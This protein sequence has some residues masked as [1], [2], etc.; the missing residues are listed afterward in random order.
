MKKKDIVREAALRSTIHSIPK[1]VSTKIKFVKLIW[2]IASLFSISFCGFLIIITVNEYFHYNVVTNIQVFSEKISEFPTITYCNGNPLVTDKA[3]QYIDKLILENSSNQNSLTTFPFNESEKLKSNSVDLFY[4]FLLSKISNEMTKE[5]KMSLGY[6][7]EV[8]FVDCEFDSDYCKAANLYFHPLYGNCVKFNNGLDIDNNEIPIL[9]TRAV[10]SLNGLS[11][12]YFVGNNNNPIQIKPAAKGGILLIGNNSYLEDLQQQGIYIGTNK[13]TNIEV[14]RTFIKKL[15]PKHGDCM[16]D[17]TKSKS[18]LYKYI[19]KSKK[20][21][22]QKD[23]FELIK[24]E[25]IMDKCNCSFFIFRKLNEN[26]KNCDTFN[27]IACSV[28]YRTYWYR[29]NQNKLSLCPLECDSVEYSFTISSLSP[30]TSGFINWIRNTTNTTSHLSQNGT[31]DDQLIANSLLKINIYYNQLG[32]T[33]I[34]EF[35]NYPTLNLISNVGGTLSL[36]LGMS[37]LSL[38]EIVELVLQIILSSS[39]KNN[40]NSSN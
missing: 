40:I 14:K 5:Q 3:K 12:I 23:C 28:Y 35:E 8:A 22:R 11:A 26:T 17:L 21:Y 25:I 37:L 20:T 39:K 4:I 10:G 33:E 7:I 6:S 29:F 38:F 9:K 27:E 31:I 19:I 18:H 36:F 1:I 32:Y 30:F 2:I 15:G 16:T 24:Q 34:K 13:E